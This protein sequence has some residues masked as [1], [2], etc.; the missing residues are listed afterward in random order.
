MGNY[1]DAEIEDYV[2]SGEP[3]D[4]AGS[5]AIQGLGGRL[6]ASI[7]GCYTNVVGLPVCE[8]AEVLRE[9]GIKVPEAPAVCADNAG[10]PCPRLG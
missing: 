7:E 1:T 10:N 2:R 5:Y 8:V 3:L 6:V 9:F 4:K